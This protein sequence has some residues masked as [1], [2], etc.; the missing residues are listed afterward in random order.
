VPVVLAQHP[1]KSLVL[2]TVVAEEPLT[3]YVARSLPGL[4]DADL[5]RAYQAPS[6]PPASSHD[7][8]Q[9]RASGGRSVSHFASGHAQREGGDA[10]IFFRLSLESN[11]RGPR[12]PFPSEL[13]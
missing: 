2:A 12:G 9:A 1:E 13:S 7:A 8:A 3:G 11:P 4:A 5:R 10:R 6:A